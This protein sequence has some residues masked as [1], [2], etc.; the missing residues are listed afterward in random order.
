VRHALFIVASTLPSTLPST[1]IGGPK[2]HVLKLAK[3]VRLKHD[4]V[5]GG[6]V[7]LAPEA[8][9]EL[10]AQ[11]AEVLSLCD[12]TRS[13]EE[14]VAELATRYDGGEVAGD[15]RAFLERVVGRGWVQREQPTS[16]GST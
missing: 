15:I 12:G 3:R 7:L 14:L 8:V 2:R 4:A 11:G 1:S 9:I 13:E 5:R 16:T 6:T 10:N